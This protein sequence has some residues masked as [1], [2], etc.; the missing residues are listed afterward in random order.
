MKNELSQYHCPRWE[1]LTDIPLYLDQILMVTQ[2]ATGVFAEDN[3]QGLTKTMINNYVKQKF[4]QP[5]QGKKYDKV[6]MASLIVISLLKRVFSMDEIRSLID[7]MIDE[8]GMEKAYNTFCDR[9]EILCREGD[10]GTQLEAP[11]SQTILILDAA[12]KALVNKWRA[13]RFLKQFTA[14]EKP[15]EHE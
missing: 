7:C 11:E 15:K 6:H 4:I 10:E 9:L 2:S 3:E 12:L 5:P 1:E 14:E 13:Q 8:C